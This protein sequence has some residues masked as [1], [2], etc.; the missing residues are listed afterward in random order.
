[1]RLPLSAHPCLWL[2]RV[3]PCSRR[4]LHAGP[5]LY[6]RQRRKGGLQQTAY[7]GHNRAI[8]RLCSVLAH[9]LLF[10]ICRAR[11]RTESIS[12]MRETRCLRGVCLEGSLSSA[13]TAQKER[14][15]AGRALT[16]DSCSETAP[17]TTFPSMPPAELCTLCARC[18]A[19][20]SMGR[21][22]VVS[23]S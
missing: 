2:T 7:G 20:A 17:G 14:V 13:D 3:R 21:F 4:R 5:C 16:R 8:Q 11:T 12:S 10:A 1:M 6:A 18:V 9:A 23:G 19:R 15:L 22:A